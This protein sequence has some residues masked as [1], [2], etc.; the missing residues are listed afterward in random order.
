VWGA[1]SK[2]RSAT[3]AR[4][5][6][7][8]P[9]SPFTADEVRRVTPGAHLVTPL[10]GN[11]DASFFQAHDAADGPFRALVVCRLVDLR[12]KGL[13]T[14]ID[15]VQLVAADPTVSRPVELR[16]AGTGPAASELDALIAERDRAGVVRA[17]GRLEDDALREE[18]RRADVVILISRHE[19]GATPRGEG[20]GLVVLEAAAAGTTA[21]AAKVGGSRDIVIDGETGYLIEASDADA[22]AAALRSLVAD[23][24]RCVRLGNAAR[25]LVEREHTFAAFAERVRDAVDQTLEP[26]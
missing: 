14:A 8:W 9:I 23:P 15:A 1:P 11:I 18:Y 22:L 4:A 26:R 6:A 17:L 19:R 2:L 24:E 13:D 7:V 12:H 5:D 10:G 3:F 21:I 16:I 20:L 25:D